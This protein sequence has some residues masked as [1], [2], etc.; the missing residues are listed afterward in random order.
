M[1]PYL[2]DME[3][4]NNAVNAGIAENAGNDLR[5]A[6]KEGPVDDHIAGS[7]RKAVRANPGFLTFTTFSAIPAL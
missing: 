5:D 2:P 3:L 7:S 4:S 1:T 6:G